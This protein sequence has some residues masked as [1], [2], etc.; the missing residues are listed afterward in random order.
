MS[1]NFAAA[2]FASVLYKRSMASAPIVSFKHVPCP[3]LSVSC[4]FGALE[5]RALAISVNQPPPP[6]LSQSSLMGRETNTTGSGTRERHHFRLTLCNG[7]VIS[8]A[9]LLM[10]LAFIIIVYRLLLRRTI[11]R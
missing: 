1:A 5:T 4:V 11:K 8:K 9:N 3:T 2:V 10:T 6:P 7:I